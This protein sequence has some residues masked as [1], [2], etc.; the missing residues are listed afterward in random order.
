MEFVYFTQ[1]Y[2]DFKELHKSILTVQFP[3]LMVFDSKYN[4]NSDIYAMKQIAE[5]S[6]IKDLKTIIIP[7]VVYETYLASLVFEMLTFEKHLKPVREDPENIGDGT[8]SDLFLPKNYYIG[9]DG[10]EFMKRIKKY[11]MC[12]RKE[13]DVDYRYER[14]KDGISSESGGYPWKK[15]IKNIYQNLNDN[16]NIELIYLMNS[17]F[18]SFLSQFPK[19]NSEDKKTYSKR[20]VIML[21]KV[22]H[23]QTTRLRNYA[24]TMLGSLGNPNN[25]EQ[26][27]SI[28]D[29]VYSN[30]KGIPPEDMF[31]LYRTSNIEY[32][33]LIAQPYYNMK[34]VNYM[35]SLSYS[36][37]LFDGQFC[38]DGASA[39]GLWDRYPENSD[40]IFCGMRNFGLHAYPIS[41]K[42]YMEHISTDLIGTTP[43][44]IMFIP[45]ISRL[46]ALFRSGEISHPRTK[47]LKETDEARSLDIDPIS[48]KDLNYLHIPCR[49]NYKE[50]LDELNKMVQGWIQQTAIPVMSMEQIKKCI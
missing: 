5:N 13:V 37:G 21:L 27:A 18:F 10:L 47:I 25:V 1:N 16:D 8:Y 2:R 24:F 22:I 30:H 44:P 17:S 35:Q 32:D 7:S 28:I 11:N 20:L 39:I 31:I 6:G 49:G 14:V 40:F 19:K 41:K 43:L 33:S 29:I 42:K 4:P 12:N 45:P 36:Q 26:I 3:T 50:C 38:D 23:A 48:P 34:A 46:M 15:L 9:T